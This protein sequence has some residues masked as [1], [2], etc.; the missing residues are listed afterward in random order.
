MGRVINRAGAPAPGV[1][2]TVRDQWGNQADAISKAGENDFGMFDFPL[3]SSTPQEIQLWVVDEAGNPLSPTF[4][5]AHKLGEAQ[6][7][8]CHH[9]VLLGE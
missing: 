7:A 6:D 9:V 4:R 5:V 2:I 8:P 1:H 3:P